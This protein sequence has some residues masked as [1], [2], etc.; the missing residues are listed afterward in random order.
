MA[1]LRLRT[2]ARPVTAQAIDIA[3]EARNREIRFALIDDLY[4]FPMLLV[5]RL[6]AAAFA[7]VCLRLINHCGRAS[8]DDA[9]KGAVQQIPYDDLDA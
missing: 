8:D 4:Q 5:G 1:L 3:A 7:D 6:N 2:E 9:Y